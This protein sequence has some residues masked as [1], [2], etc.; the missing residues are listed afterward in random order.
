MFFKLIALLT[1][2]PNNFF[3]SNIFKPEHRELGGETHPD[4]TTFFFP[5]QKKERKKIISLSFLKYA[6]YISC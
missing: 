4:F 2:G 1:S 6:L 5:P 3:G